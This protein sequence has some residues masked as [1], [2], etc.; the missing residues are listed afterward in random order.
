MTVSPPRRRRDDE[1]RRVGEWMPAPGCRKTSSR[2][3]PRGCVHRAKEPICNLAPEYELRASM[4]AQA[5]ISARALCCWRESRKLQGVVL[6]PPIVHFV[7]H[8]LLQ[9]GLGPAPPLCIDN[10][11]SSAAGGAVPPLCIDNRL[12]SAASRAEPPLIID[13]I[14]AWPPA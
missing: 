6:P 14:S 12:S 4:Q 9:R 3:W 2:R 7:Y 10:H 8:P 5:A 1:R 13:S 11:L